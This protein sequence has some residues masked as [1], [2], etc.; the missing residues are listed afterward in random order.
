MPDI[1]IARRENIMRWLKEQ[2]SLTIE[3]LAARLGVSN[4]TVHRDLDY[5]VQM[6]MVSKVHGGV[7]L[8]EKRRSNGA[9]VCKVCG[10]AIAERTSFV[11]QT[12]EGE[13]LNT[14][15]PHC[16]F[17]LLN[18]IKQ[19]VTVLAKDFL[20]GRVMNA[21]YAFYV[22]NSTVALC[23][24]PSHLCFATPD[25][26]RRFQQGFDGQIM[27]FPEAQTYMLHHQAN[28]VQPE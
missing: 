1:P 6:G 11:I 19:P 26:A 25:D 8:A 16:G 10:I 12:M 15:C 27:T 21:R 7:T 3:D 5:L 17:L 24:M 22:V 13:Q 23:C 18:E 14:C 20:Y 9:P 4:M 2:P 28:P